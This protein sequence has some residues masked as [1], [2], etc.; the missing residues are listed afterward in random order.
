MSGTPNRARICKALQAEECASGA[1]G[2][3]EAE[4][5]R[6]GRSQAGD[7]GS[8]T[9]LLPA[10][11]S[12]ALQALKQNFDLM[13]NNMTQRH[14]VELSALQ[15]DADSRVA[16]SEA[17]LNALE[18]ERN[19]WKDRARTTR[20]DM[21]QLEKEKSDVWWTLLAV[22]WS[23]SQLLGRIASLETE[24]QQYIE[25]IE[26]GAAEIKDSQSTVE[27][28]MAAVGLAKRIARASMAH[29]CGSW[30]STTSPWRD[31][32]SRCRPRTMPF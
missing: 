29:R 12:P 2:A 26:R 24:K 10:L 4:A 9:R 32:S 31:G 27:A 25:T 7:C 11:L 19:V 30:R 28:K 8:A 15:H 17:A 1:G 5:R 22:S 18:A 20:N 6:I 16:S 21:T 23:R 13:V 14:A 3:G